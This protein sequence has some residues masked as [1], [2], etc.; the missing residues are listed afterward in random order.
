MCP[1]G[2]VRVQEGQA[3][4]S[5]DHVLPRFPNRRSLVLP[6]RQAGSLGGSVRFQIVQVRQAALAWGKPPKPDK[7]STTAYDQD[8][9]V[10]GRLQMVERRANALVARPAAHA[11]REHALPQASCRQTSSV[12]VVAAQ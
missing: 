8:G 2:C 6:R 11:A 1:F 5:S 10:D 12:V 7:G 4:L 9:T 3:T